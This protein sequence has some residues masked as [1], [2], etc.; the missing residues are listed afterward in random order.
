VQINTPYIDCVWNH[1]E[2]SAS[3]RSSAKIQALWETMC[4]RN[5]KRKA[6][7]SQGNNICCLQPTTRTFVHTWAFVLICS[8]LEVCCLRLILRS[9]LVTPLALINNQFFE[10]NIWKSRVLA[11][12]DTFFHL[13]LLKEGNTSNM[14]VILY[15]IHGN[16]A[17]RQHHFYTRGEK[18][19]G[20]CITASSAYDAQ[21]P[22][23]FFSGDSK[24]IN[25]FLII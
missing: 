2:C 12:R 14:F 4:G 15:G 22:S 9:K 3:W 6:V 25:L 20:N 5:G 8:L 19:R 1:L 23:F 18:R 16:L 10:D 7:K 24:Q 11:N 21:F 17:I 13:I